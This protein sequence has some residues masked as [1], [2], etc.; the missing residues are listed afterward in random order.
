MPKKLSFYPRYIKSLMLESLKDSPTV[1]IHGPRQC[2]KTTL[3]QTVGKPKGYEYISFDDTVALSSAIEDPKGFITNLPK[4]VI[5]DEVQKAPHIFSALKMRIDKNRVPGRFILTGS[6]N[7]LNMPKLSDS[8]AGRMQILRLHPLSQE[9]IAQRRPYFLSA[10]FKGKFKIKKPRNT[11]T[12]IIDRIL[13]GGFP[14]AFKLPA[15]RRRTNWYRNYIDTLVKR[16]IMDI[17]KVRSIEIIPKLLMLSSTHTAQ[18]VNFTALS[19]AFQVS[20][21][22]IVDYISLLE[23]M[24]FLTKLPPWHTSRLRRLIKTPK[25]HLSD[26][27]LACAV[28]GMNAESLKNNRSL[29]GHLLETFVFQEL[30]RQ[31]S[32]SKYHHNFFHYRDKKCAEVDIVIERDYLIVGIE[33]KASATVNKGD[34]KG[35]L[36]LKKATG[37]R[38]VCGVVLYDG[39]MSLSFGN[40]MYAVPLNTFLD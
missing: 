1:L 28:L 27:G 23:Q 6:A 32:Y 5:L 16:D 15:G 25:I 13:T 30:C 39:E 10:V 36:A 21:S 38:F 12:H 11:S 20:R 40:K 9:E 34:F 19:K 26:T 29:L 17:S 31:A 7:I 4:K 37:K 14:S 8:L 22:T 18:L 33:V 24:F 2:G 35:L 3:A